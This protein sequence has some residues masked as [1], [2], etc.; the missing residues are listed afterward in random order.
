MELFCSIDPIKSYFSDGLL[1][2]DHPPLSTASEIPSNW[3][4]PNCGAMMMVLH[5]LT[6]VELSWC[7]YFDTS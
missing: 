4:C 6:A 2:I 3:H 5:R 7:T 1:A